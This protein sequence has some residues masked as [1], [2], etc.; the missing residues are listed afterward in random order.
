MALTW[1]ERVDDPLLLGKAIGAKSVALFHLGRHREAVILARGRVALAEAAGSLVDQERAR[2]WVAVCVLDE[3]PREALSLMFEAAELARRAGR[4]DRETLNLLNAV[5]G[6]ILLG[7]WGDARAALNALGQRDLA[8]ARQTQLAC[9]EA[10]LAALSGDTSRA[11]EQLEACVDAARSEDLAERTT[12]LQARAVV[13]LA[14]GELET[15][16]REAAAAVAAE[17]SGINSPMAL[18]MQLR[19]AL[20]LGDAGLAREALVGMQGFRGRWMAA[21]RLTGEAGLAAL[22]ERHDDAA[23]TYIRAL[24]AWRVLESPLD[25][26]LCAL[27]RAILRGPGSIPGGE[28]DEARAILTELGATPLLARLDHTGA[29]ARKVG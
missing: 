22:E 9:C 25:L 8:S 24:D 7:R 27:D 10:M 6:A 4:R 28:Y 20:W 15:A 29:A 12:Y 16:H 26:A 11:V 17:P 2:A 21:A 18:A 3:D 5:E 23:A 13:S 14:A 19:S 1:A